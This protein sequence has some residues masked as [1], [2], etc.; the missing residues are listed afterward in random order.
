MIIIVIV[1]V[2]GLLDSLLLL[3]V[4]I[5]FVSHVVSV[6]GLFILIFKFPFSLYLPATAAKDMLS[7]K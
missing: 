3:F 6:S 4:V 7:S 5:I 1:V 2:S